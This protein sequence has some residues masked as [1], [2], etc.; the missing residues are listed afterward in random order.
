M[1]ELQLGSNLVQRNHGVG[2]GKD[3]VNVV[4]R[5]LLCDQSEGGVVLH[6]LEKDIFFKGAKCYGLKCYLHTVPARTKTH[7]YK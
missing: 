4:L 5:H 1:V 2:H 3:E 6:R 7:N